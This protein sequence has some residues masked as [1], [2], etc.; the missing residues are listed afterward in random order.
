M[1]DEGLLTYRNILYIP[2]FDD[3]KRFIIDELHKR[4]YNGH[5]GYQKM[6]TTTRKKFYWPGLKKDIA[7]YLS[8]CLEFQQVKAKH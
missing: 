1:L 4:P 2:S 7:N 5:P 8:N 3:L 6:I